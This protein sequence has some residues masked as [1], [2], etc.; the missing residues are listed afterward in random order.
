MPPSR[1]PA[2]LLLALHGLAA[3][4]ALFGGL[5][6]A[7]DPAWA[8]VH[9][10]VALW[11]ALVNLADWTCPLTVLEQRLR[12]RSPGAY[13]GGCLAHHVGRRLGPGLTARG[14]ERAAGLGFLGVNAVL[15]AWLLRTAP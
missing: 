5:L 1:L 11:F 9:A 14:L 10:P 8:W 7:R 6:L 3:A 15:Y 12:D 13:A 4:F 2:D